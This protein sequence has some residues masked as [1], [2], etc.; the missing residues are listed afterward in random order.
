MRD[1]A[2]DYEFSNA[3]YRVGARSKDPLLSK[4]DWVYDCRW[5]GIFLIGEGRG[6]E[7]VR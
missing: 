7:S 2:W 1:K 3:Q 6:M 5:V 4:K